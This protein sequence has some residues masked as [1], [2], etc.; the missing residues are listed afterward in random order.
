MKHTTTWRFIRKSLSKGLILVGI[1]VLSL[2]NTATTMAQSISITS[3]AAGAT[4]APNANITIQVATSGSVTNVTYWVDSYVWIGNNSSSP[5]SLNWTNNLA[6]GSHVIKA[7]ANFSNGTSIDAV[8]RTITVGTGGGGGGGGT[9]TKFEAESAQLTG[10]SVASS[11]S[12]YSGSGYI[13]PSSFD[14]NGD[15][16]TFTVNVV[17]GGNYP[18]VIRYG[19]FNGD[20]SQTIEVNGA[21]VSNCATN[22]PA[23]SA[24]TDS[25]FGN[26]A[27][28][29]GNNTIAIVKCYGYMAID[30]ITVGGSTGGGGDTQAPSVPSGLSSASISQTSFTLNWSAAS[31]NVGVTGYEVFRNGSSIG[32]PTSTSFNVSGLSASTA[33]SMTVRARDAAGNWSSQSSSLSVTTSAA[34]GGGTGTGL[35]GEYYN[36]KTLSSPSVLTRTDATVNNDYGNGS[37]AA[38]VNADNFSVRWTGQVEAPVSGSYTFSTTSDDGVRLFVNGNQVI[39]NWTDHGPVTDNS[40][41]IS[42]TA[43]QKYTISMEYYES[44]GGAVARLLWAYPGQSQQIIPQTRLFPASGGGDTQLP[45]TPASVATSAVTQTSVTI[46]WNASTDNVGVTGYDV[47]RNGSFLASTSSTSYNAT[48]LNCNTAYSF[49]VKAKDAAGN[50]SANSSTVNAT[51]SACA[52]VTTGMTAGTQ[53]WNIAWESPLNFFVSGVNWSSTSNPWNPTFISELQ[54]AQIKTL[55]FMDWNNTNDISA[56]NWSQRIS[57]TANHY[58][59]DN[60]NSNYRHDY[61]AGTNTHTIVQDAE[62]GFGVAYEWQIDLCNRL[63]ADLWMNIPMNSSADYQ[64]QLATLIKNNLNSN[65]KVYVEYSNETWNTSFSTWVYAYQNGLALGLNNLNYNGAFVEPWR[66]YTVYASVRAFQQ[67]ENV[68]GVNSSRIVKVIAGQV[69]YHWPGFDFNHQT[70]GDLAALANSTI[71]PN[72]ITINAYAVAPYMGGQSMAEQDA[73]IDENVQGVVWAKNTLNGTGIKL[74]VYEGG[75]D[76]FTDQNLALTRNPQQQSL[77]VEYLSK[78]DDHI[79]GPFNQYTFYGG[80]WGLKNFAGE[81]PSVASKWRGWIDYWVNGVRAREGDEEAIVSSD[82]NSFSVYPNPANDVL[83]IKAPNDAI[84]LEILDLTGSLL[85]SIK[86]TELDSKVDIRDLSQSIYM[87][88]IIKSNGAKTSLKFIKN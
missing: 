40:A 67:F 46:S 20:K 33:Y 86:I 78:L 28:N 44:G 84:K 59:V 82:D 35:R 17:S 30:Y 62:Q 80:P 6:N 81:S 51:T 36:N 11:Q 2:V 60:R 14:A 34:T 58:N 54:Q 16:V 70:Q 77:Y 61:N 37:P 49:Y 12:G 18:L 83:N 24:F 43:G 1:P 25:N 53:F 45:S 74:M 3:P 8:D 72:G 4:I 27:L 41:G 88:S 50:Q 29:A 19:G 9:T 48:G 68:F 10:V 22:F 63:G 66:A 87:I 76:N 32:T 42:L 52:V 5:F 79:D 71:N 65:L 75:S 55:R 64:F 21:T 7:R 47:Y 31:D 13:D 26:V 69:G 57:K 38:G 73:A 15:K 23:S 39:N 56:R 85:K